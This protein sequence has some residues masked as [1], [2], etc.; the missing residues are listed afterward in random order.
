M[1][2]NEVSRFEKHKPTDIPCNIDIDTKYLDSIESTN[3]GV[4][5]GFILFA[6]KGRIVCS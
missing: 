5:G 3:T 6:R 1:L 2:T 4:I